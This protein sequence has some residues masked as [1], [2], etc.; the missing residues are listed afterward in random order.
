MDGDAVRATLRDASPA[1]GVALALTVGSAVT[2]ITTLPVFLLPF[3]S[4][5]VRVAL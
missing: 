2:E 4:V 5:S 1:V 3:V